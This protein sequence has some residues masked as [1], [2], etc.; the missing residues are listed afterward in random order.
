MAL[1]S[2]VAALPRERAVSAISACFLSAGEGHSI[3]ADARIEHR[4]RNTAVVRTVLT[5]N[6]GRRVLVADTTHLRRR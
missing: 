3:H 2:A 6:A 4:G 5:G 1:A